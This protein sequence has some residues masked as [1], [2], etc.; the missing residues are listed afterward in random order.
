MVLAYGIKA[1]SPGKQARYIFS[2]RSSAGAEALPEPALN[3]SA[4]GLVDLFFYYSAK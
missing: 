4:A 3:P 1:N 2:S